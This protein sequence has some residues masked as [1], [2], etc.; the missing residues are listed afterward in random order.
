MDTKGYYRF[1]VGEFECVCLSDGGHHY[2]PQNF[3]ANV[4]KEQVTEV[5]RQHNLPTDQIW[6]PYTCLYVKTGEHRVLVD[7]GAGSLF[8][9]TGKLPHSMG[10]ASVN[11]VD[12]DAVLITHAHPDHIGGTLDSTGRPIYPNTQ[13]FIRKEEWEFWFSETAPTK[14]SEFFVTFARQHLLPLRDRMNFIDHEADILPGIR[15][16]PAHGHTPGHAV[17]SFSSGKERLLYI[18]DTVLH[19]LHLEH[20]AW[21]PI[22]DI[23]P[24][25]A[26]LSKQNVLNAAAEN[27]AW[28]IGHHFPPFPGLGHIVKKDNAW[29]WRPI[30]SQ[31]SISRCS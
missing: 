4:F 23:L 21:L 22:Y 24:E 10:N 1:K 19:P 20:P 2:P 6:T 13:Y 31:A 14:A 17:I 25:H 15:M 26:A 3:F 8:G 28:V 5:L 12:I 16:L 30:E 18:G 27:Q 9:T 11:P 7:T 29:R